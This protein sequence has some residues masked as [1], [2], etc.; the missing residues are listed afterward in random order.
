MWRVGVLRKSKEDN[1]YL[2]GHNFGKT[3]R[4]KDRQTDI[5]VQKEE[6]YTSKK[7]PE[8]YA[9]VLYFTFLAFTINGQILENVSSHTDAVSPN[10]K[11]FIN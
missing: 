8:T 6:S 1:I 2:K 4:P 11:V 7:I 9:H 5:V 10:M 3:D